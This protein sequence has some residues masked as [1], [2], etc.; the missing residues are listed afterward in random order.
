[1][2]DDVIVSDEATGIYK[3]ITLR[4]S[5]GGRWQEKTKMPRITKIIYSTYVCIIAIDDPCISK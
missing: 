3:G 4:V 2:N 1:M 5:T